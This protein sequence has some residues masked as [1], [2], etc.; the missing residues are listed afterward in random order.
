MGKSDQQILAIKREHL[1]PEGIFQGFKSSKDIDYESRILNHMEFV[2]RGSTSEPEN[3]PLGNAELSKI[4][5]QPIGYAIL[6]NI[7][8]KEVFAYKRAVQD[9]DYSEKRL[10]GKWSWGFGGHIEFSDNQKGNPIRESMIREVTR[11]ELEI[12]G[13]INEIIPLGYIND[14]LDSVGRVHFGI[15]YLINTNATR[16]EPKDKEAEIVEPKK[17]IGLEE[18]CNSTDCE[19]ESWSRIALDSL[20]RILK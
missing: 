15:L 17:L 18:L 14:E 4:Y 10:Q 9:K 8:R 6:A 20:R 1:F 11:E 16:V 12:F 2:R 5:K 3:H 19:V 7:S 13:K